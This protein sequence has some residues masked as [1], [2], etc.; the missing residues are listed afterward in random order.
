MYLNKFNAKN[1]YGLFNFDLKLN[2]KLNIIIGSNGTGKTTV[3]KI[4]LSIFNLD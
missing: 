2:K 1:I 3:L 4:I